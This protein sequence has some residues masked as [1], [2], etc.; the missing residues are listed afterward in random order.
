MQSRIKLVAPR[1]KSPT[2][3]EEALV[4]RHSSR[5]YLPR[6]IQ[7]MELAQLLWAAQGI[8]R[9]DRS[10]TAPSAGALYPLEIYGLVGKVEGL[11]T[12]VYHY[13]PGDHALIRVHDADKRAELSA[14]ALGQLPV[15]NGAAV[16]LICALYERTTRK[17]GERGVYYVHMEAGHAAQN[18]HL[19]AA[20]LDIGTVIIGAFRDNEVQEILGLA[21]DV[22]PLCLMPVGKI[23]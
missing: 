12:G 20:A 8:N 7:L 19:Q 15:K 3:I 4:Q 1:E 18:I 6:P 5:N 16:I 13:Q 22:K 21:K 14:A 23:Q 17:Y 11:E 9:P 2:S 10:R